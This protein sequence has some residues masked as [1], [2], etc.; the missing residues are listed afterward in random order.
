MAIWSVHTALLQEARQ[1]TCTAIAAAA[2][3]TAAVATVKQV[4]LQV[5]RS[6]LTQRHVPQTN[7]TPPTLPPAGA[8][9]AAI[10]NAL[11]VCLHAL[12]CVSYLVSEQLHKHRVPAAAINDVRSSHTLRARDTR[13]H[14][15]SSMS[16]V[17]QHTRQHK[18]RW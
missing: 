5:L 2:F 12:N 15:Q 17:G 18:Q 1:A 14:S 7:M 4:E 16:A 11:R 8:A 6:C 9:A 3:A 10:S 13:R